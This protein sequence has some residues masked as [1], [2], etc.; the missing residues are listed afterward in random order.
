MTAF[1]GIGLPTGAARGDGARLVTTVWLASA[2]GGFALAFAGAFG[3][4]RAARVG[5]S[6]AAVAVTLG[7]CT[8]SADIL[9]DA[10]ATGRAFTNVS[11]ETAITAPGA[12][13]L[14]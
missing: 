13:W 1:V 6:G 9:T 7:C 4:I 2:A 10:A 11:R 3:P 12:V 14:T 8:S 5:A